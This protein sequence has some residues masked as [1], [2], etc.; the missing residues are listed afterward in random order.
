MENVYVSLRGYSQG[1]GKDILGIF[2]D[3]GSAVQRC[4]EERNFI[5]DSWK[6][7]HGWIDRWENG[8]GMYV[9]VAEYP[10]E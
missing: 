2:S 5:R 8:M 9:M 10:V 3:H 6:P 7:A 1:A 4:M